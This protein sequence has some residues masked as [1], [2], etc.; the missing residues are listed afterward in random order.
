MMTPAEAEKRQ[1]AAANTT[2][3]LRAACNMNGQELTEP[4]RHLLA[5]ARADLTRAAKALYQ[6]HLLETKH[7][8]GEWRETP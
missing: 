5:G 1:E 8:R 4:S 7:Q 2:A 6:I 3:A